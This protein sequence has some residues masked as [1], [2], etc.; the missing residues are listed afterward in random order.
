[1]T[2][3]TKLTNGL[4]RASGAAAVVFLVLIGAIIIAQVGARLLGHQ[5]PS[6]NDFSAWCMGASLF[7]ALPDTL[8]AEEH[9]RV[10]LLLDRAGPKLSRTMDVLSTLIGSGALIWGSWHM[11]SYTYMSWQYHD[12]SQG[13]IAFPLWI[14]QSAVALGLVLF[15]LAMVERLIRLC[16]GIDLPK[17]PSA[18][19]LHEV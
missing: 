6:A 5:I 2:M 12:V 14:P 1:M 10:S 4:F 16:L 11:V 17:P 8:R 9:I 15:L 18:L 7:L 19:D 3:L 13:I